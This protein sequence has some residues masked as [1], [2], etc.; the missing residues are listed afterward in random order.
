MAFGGFNQQ[1]GSAPMAEIN[2]VPLIDVM[3]VLLVIFMVTAP[4]MS[5]ALKIDLPSVKSAP[6]KPAEKI[7]LSIDEQGQWFWNGQPLGRQEITTRLDATGQRAP[8][9]E[10]HLRIDK[11]TRYEQIAE[12]MSDAVQAGL[13]KIG[14]ITQ[15]P[16]AMPATPSR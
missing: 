8:E 13:S 11:N 7:D 10:L 15:P 14:F 5:H 9:T 4:L 2:M 12:V 16:V 1:S 6:V 3:L